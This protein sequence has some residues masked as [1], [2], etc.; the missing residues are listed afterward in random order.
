MVANFGQGSE[1]KQAKKKIFYPH[2]V[3]SSSF[4]LDPE[5]L[6]AFGT[7]SLHQGCFHFTPTGRYSVRRNSI[8]DPIS[9][10]FVH[11][12]FLVSHGAL[13]CRGPYPTSKSVHERDTPQAAVLPGITMPGL[14]FL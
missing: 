13:S 3:A 7:V 9:N 6:S 8:L 12:G 11:H 10:P 14:F 5:L 2:R 4:P 1:E